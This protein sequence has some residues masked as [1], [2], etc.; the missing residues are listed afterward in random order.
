MEEFDILLVEDD[1]SLLEVTKD[2]LEDNEFRVKTCTNGSGA[3]DL[4][5]KMSFKLIVL[6][7]NLPD[8]IG[9]D[10]CSIIRKSSKVPIIFLSARISDR[11]KITGLDLGADDYISKPYSLN[12]LLYRI[13]AQIRRKYDYDSEMISESFKKPQENKNEDYFTFGNVEIDFIAR[14]ILISGEQKD[15]PAK[16]FDLLE[17]FIKNRNKSIP[18]E[19][20]YN[21]IWGFDSMGEISTLSVH[22]RRLRE[23]IEEDPSNPKFLKTI[24][25]VGFRFE[26]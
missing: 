8:L 9:F 18:K 16:E 21:E 1:L 6:D 11:D 5:K 13:K 25:S 7:I 26:V 3:I 2:F 10:V 14:K 17:Y 24:W 23:K 15:F 4:V 22:I 20:L 19:T 12:E